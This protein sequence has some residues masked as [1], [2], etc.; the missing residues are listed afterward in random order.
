[1]A[2]LAT[3]VLV[4]AAWA[5]PFQVAVGMKV[6]FFGVLPGVIAL[7][8]PLTAR[9]RDRLVSILLAT[10][11]VTAVVGLAQQV[12]GPAR[13]NELG[14]QYNSVIRFTGSLMR[15]WSTFNQPFAFGFFLMLVLLIALAAALDD[16]GRRRSVITFTA[17]PVLLAAMFFTVVR[18]AWIG[19]AIGVSYLAVRRYR[20]MLRLLPMVAGL[21][22]VAAVIGLFAFFDS[23]SAG[24]RLS[25]WRPLPGVVAE[26]PFGHGGG[27]AGAAAAKA[28]EL[29]GTATTFTP[30]RVTSAHLVYQP[31]NSYVE[32]LY[33]DGVIGLA[34]FLIALQLVLR[35][36]R[37]SET[38][39]PD[40]AFAVGVSA[41]VLAAAVACVGATFFEIFPLDYL[42]WL[43]AGV[44]ST[45]LPLRSP[46]PPPGIAAGAAGAPAY[47]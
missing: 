37:R 23:A 45:A 18:T 46:V 17:T 43:L 14:Y 7:R 34:L 26:A 1:M 41:V 11:C 13:L 25:R 10:G 15:S 32:V 27:S 35:T 33:E 24:D 19:L 42:F 2:L 47:A 40:P 39:G 5:P 44:T 29:T 8:C 3:V 4:T 16:R 30:G 31:D 21:A 36:T 9:D 22:A 6:A 28:N 20:R 38:E 12:V